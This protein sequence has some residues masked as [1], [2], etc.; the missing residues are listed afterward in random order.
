MIQ[1]T[2]SKSKYAAYRRRAAARS[3]AKKMAARPRISRGLTARVQPVHAFTRMAQFTLTGSV[4]NPLYGVASF[5]LN[6]LPNF[7]DFVNLF[8][9]YQITF[10]KLTW[11]LNLDPGAQAAASS[12]YPRLYTFNDFTDITT[13]VSLDEFREQQKTKIQMLSPGRTVVTTCKPAVLSEVTKTVG[14]VT[15]TA[16]RW[17]QWFPT[18]SADVQHIGTKYAVENF[19]NTNYTITLSVKYYLKCKAVK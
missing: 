16:P 11:Q 19:T 15:V 5:A 14:G 7:N 6:G 18:S 10:A 17:N 3:K 9:I 13:P 8:D 1:G 12:Q 2:T 4:A